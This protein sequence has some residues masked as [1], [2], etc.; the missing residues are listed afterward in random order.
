MSDQ[1]NTTWGFWVG[2]WSGMILGLFVG[3]IALVG[4]GIWES[5]RIWGEMQ[6]KAVT[7]EDLN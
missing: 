4:Q 3:N 6:C 5:G 2:I 1:I 7:N